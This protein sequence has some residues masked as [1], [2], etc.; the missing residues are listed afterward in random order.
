MQFRC[1]TMHKEQR[2]QLAY[3]ET[4]HES[5]KATDDKCK[6]NLKGRHRNSLDKTIPR[7][8]SV[9]LLTVKPELNIYYL[10]HEIGCKP[11]CDQPGG[12]C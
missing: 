2:Y 3:Y 12:E 11:S 9:L 6:A 8:G 10:G 4:R 1:P 7:N 5:L